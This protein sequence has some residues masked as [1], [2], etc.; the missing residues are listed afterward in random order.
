MEGS[1]DAS[2]AEKKENLMLSKEVL[3]KTKGFEICSQSV[4][5]WPLASLRLILLALLI[6][7]KNL[8]I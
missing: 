6:T 7:F 3:T 1:Q 2:S 8:L 5:F 4:L